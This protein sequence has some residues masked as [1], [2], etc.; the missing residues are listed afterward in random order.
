MVL[1]DEIKC[2]RE[3]L[4][5][6]MHLAEAANKELEMV[7]IERDAA[8]AKIEKLDAE[9]CSYD[10]TFKLYATQQKEKI[11]CL[12]E[13]LGQKMHLVEA[14][15][16]KME[17]AMIERDESNSKIDKL[18]AEICSND[19][20]FKL[21]ATQQIV[22]QDEIK[23]LREELGWKMHLVEAANKD[24]E[25]VVIERDEANAKIDKLEAELCSCNGKLSDVEKYIQELKASL[26]KQL[27]NFETLIE[28]VDNNKT[29][30]NETILTAD[31]SFVASSKGF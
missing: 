18:E 8:N 16:K 3:E 12:R 27:V 6:K 15:N 24:F 19:D 4:G 2:L 22:L 20:T 13:E 31:A 23:C 21:Y 10:D 5:Q 25:M 17:M 26:K 30:L 14:A 7:V 1:E 9:I 29:N 11:K 28:L